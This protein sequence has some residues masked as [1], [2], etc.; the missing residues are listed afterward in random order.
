MLHE[1]SKM[2]TNY[3]IISALLLLLLA[4]TGCA[5]NSN[6]NPVVTAELE[7]APPS[8]Y[9][10]GSAFSSANIGGYR[11]YYGTIP[12]SY[13]DYRDVGNTTSVK[14]SSLKL[15]TRENYY[16]TVTVYD[17]NGYESDFSN[18]VSI[19]ANLIPLTNN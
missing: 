12:G 1:G 16:A 17:T 7:W 10:D 14:I 15:P 19:P 18:V 2:H 13:C 8:T 4:F 3:T 11:I 5:G 6:S 9:S